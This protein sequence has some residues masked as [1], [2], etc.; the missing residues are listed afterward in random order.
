MKVSMQAHSVPGTPRAT[1]S[2]IKAAAN[3]LSATAGPAT[4]LRATLW[5]PD[6]PPE[7][8]MRLILPILLLIFWSISGSADHHAEASKISANNLSDIVKVMASDEF[9]GRAPG[10]PR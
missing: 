2:R 1:K 10:T 4:L 3:R 7:L 6:L 8:A 9:E 5:L